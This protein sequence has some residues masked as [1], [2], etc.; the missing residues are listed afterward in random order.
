VP[1]VR[2]I[3][4]CVPLPLI[5]LILK[6]SELSAELKPNVESVSETCIIVTCATGFAVT[7][8]VALAPVDEPSEEL[9]AFD[10]LVTAP[11][12][13]L[14]IST[15]IVQLPEAADEPPENPI[16]LPPALAVTVPPQVD[17][18]FGVAAIDMPVGKTL[19]NANPDAPINAELL[20]T[21]YVNL[22]DES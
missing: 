22:D 3:G 1:A 20:S 15:A 9:K 10:V 17:P 14:V 2:D 11:T 12:T 7:V 21:I 8:K 13:L 16:A 19:L 5:V 18:T 6:L 4:P